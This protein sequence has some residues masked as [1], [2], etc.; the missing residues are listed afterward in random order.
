[1]LSY[2]IAKSTGCAYA[3][4]SSRQQLNS[5]LKICTKCYNSFAR[6]RLTKHMC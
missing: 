3:T 1:M 6:M 5:M 2:S 4:S